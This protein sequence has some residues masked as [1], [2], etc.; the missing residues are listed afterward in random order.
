MKIS[1]LLPLKNETEVYEVDKRLR[2]IGKKK[3]KVLL[4]DVSRVNT[5]YHYR[6][7][8][9]LFPVFYICLL[10]SLGSLYETIV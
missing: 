9:E 4:E 7:I 6:V 10:L 3:N 1:F 5:E 2:G 8:L